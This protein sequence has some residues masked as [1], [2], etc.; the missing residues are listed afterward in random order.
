MV[1][2]EVKALANQTAKATEEISAQVQDIQNATGEA[3]NAIQ[4]IGGTI[5]EIDQISSQ[6]AAAVE[7]QGAATQEI[8][9]NVL[10]AANGTKEVNANIHSVDAS[11]RAIRQGGL[12]PAGSRQRIVIAVRAPESRSRQLPQFAARGVGVRAVIP[13]HAGIQYSR[14]VSDLAEKPRRTGSPHARG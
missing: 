5:A 7:Q 2:S 11:F 9:G 12:D 4:V 13:A 10:Q 8:A 1:A 14:D 3:V 6:I